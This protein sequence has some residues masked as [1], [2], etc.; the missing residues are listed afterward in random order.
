MSCQRPVCIGILNQI[1]TK[2]FYLDDFISVCDWVSVYYL[3]RPNLIDEGDNHLLELATA[4][5]A[6]YIITGNTKDFEHG[7][8]LF[9]DITIATPKEFLDQWRN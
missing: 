4:S 6:R 2:Q 1:A 9:P 8:L 3:W 7:N 5:H